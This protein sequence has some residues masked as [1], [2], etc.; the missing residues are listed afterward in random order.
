M[1]REEAKRLL[2]KEGYDVFE[3]RGFYSHFLRVRRL[4]SYSTV[5]TIDVDADNCVADKD[6]MPFVSKGK[7]RA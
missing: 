1:T 3:Q 6:V 7:K 2:T 5:T 4:P